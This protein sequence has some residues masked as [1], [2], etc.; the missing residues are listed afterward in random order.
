M[1]VTR[2]D[3]LPSAFVRTTAALVKEN[4]AMQPRSISDRAMRLRHDAAQLAR[5]T[6]W[7]GYLADNPRHIN[8]PEIDLMAA[9]R[10]CEEALAH[11]KKMLAHCEK[12][13]RKA[14]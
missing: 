6:W 5:C 4:P 2:R 8:I 3:R 12:H 9:Q 7:P 11:I 10:D 14:A 1:T 13:R